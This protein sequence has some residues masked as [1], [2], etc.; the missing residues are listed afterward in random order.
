MANY[1]TSPDGQPWSAPIY[2]VDGVTPITAPYE[3][4]L[5]VGGAPNGVLP[6]AGSTTM[7]GQNG[8]FSGPTL[9]I[10]GEPP[11]T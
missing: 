7:F 5:S 9:T 8:L 10:A 3:V 4:S 6:V 11:G 2:N 1:G